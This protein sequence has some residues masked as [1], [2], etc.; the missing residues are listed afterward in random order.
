MDRDANVATQIGSR[1]IGI[2]Q[3]ILMIQMTKLTECVVEVL[4]RRWQDPSTLDGVTV[5]AISQVGNFFFLPISSFDSTSGVSYCLLFQIIHLIAV[6]IKK[7]WA[8]STTLEVGLFY[9]IV[10]DILNSVKVSLDSSWDAPLPHQ[11]LVCLKL[12]GAISRLMSDSDTSHVR[13][14]WQEYMD[15]KKLFEKRILLELIPL[16]LPILQKTSQHF[17]TIPATQALLLKPTLSQ[18][19][20]SSIDYLTT[21]VD[22]EFSHSHSPSL[23]PTEM[24]FMPNEDWFNVLFQHST[25]TLETNASQE[26]SYSTAR[27]STRKSSTFFEDVINL[28]RSLRSD[29]ECVRHPVSLLMKRTR[30]VFTRSSHFRAT[31]MRSRLIPQVRGDEWDIISLREHRSWDADV[32]H[33]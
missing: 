24:W 30:Y 15:S 16:V 1:L 14:T 32:S 26:S 5:S 3:N 7:G 6:L 29:P 18:L 28:Y 4:F 17:E 31:R 11:N 8:H 23:L 19:L 20:E 13:I 12:I 2:D 33:V 22:W 25:T 9:P 27:S 21:F 10:Q